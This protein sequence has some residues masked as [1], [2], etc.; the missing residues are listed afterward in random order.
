MIAAVELQ[1]Y[2]VHIEQELKVCNIEDTPSYYLGND[3]KKV[4]NKYI[5]L[6]PKS[7]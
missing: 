7:T 3:I 4:M 5:H 6:S 2:I 1:K